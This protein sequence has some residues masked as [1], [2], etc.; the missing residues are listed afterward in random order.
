MSLQTSQPG[1][2][3]L[4]VLAATINE[5][6]E[7]A[8]AAT[9]RGLEHAIAVGALLIEAKELVAHG[10]WLPWLQANCRV[11]ERS[12]QVYMRLARNRHKL[13]A[14]KNESI[15]D[16][17]IPGAVALVGKPKP[18]RQPGLPGQL[19]LLGAPEVPPPVPA[20]SPLYGRA[21]LD[22]VTDLEQ[23]LAFIRDEEWRA[24]SRF[25]AAD[26]TIARTIAFLLRHLGNRRAANGGSKRRP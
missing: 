14:L 7:A 15:A 18:E 20:A 24:D 25:R 26:S 19:D 13:D 2:N 9:R 23:V 8:E 1:S 12:A 22:L 6:L 4:P 5:H 16:L 3:R 11:S 10:E 21:V 17:T